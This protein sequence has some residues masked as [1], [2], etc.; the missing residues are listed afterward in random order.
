MI[1]RFTLA[2]LTIGAT[3]SMNAERISVEMAQKIASEFTPISTSKQIKGT[4]QTEMRLTY[5][6]ESKINPQESLYYVFNRNEGQGFVIVSP[7]DRLPAV[8]GYTDHGSF[9]IENIPDNMRW[10]L[11]QY[12]RQIDDY[13]N[14]GEDMLAPTQKADRAPIATLVSARWDQRSPFNNNTPSN[15]PAGCLAVAIGQ[16][17]HYHQYPA[18]GTGSHS[19]MHPTFGELSADFGN[20]SY[21]WDYMLDEYGYFDNYSDRQANAVAT[22]IYH[23]GVAVEMDYDYYGSGAITGKGYKALME[24]FGYDDSVE[25]LRREYFSADEWDEIMY[26]ELA[27]NRPVVYT[28]QA[29]EGGHAFVCDGYNT[30]GYYHI[31]WGW[32]GS[33]DGH[34]RLDALEPYG[35]GTGGYEG[36]YNEMQDVIIGIQKPDGITSDKPVRWGTDGHFVYDKNNT[37]RVIKDDGKHGGFYNLTPD[38]VKIY[39]GIKIVNTATE[40]VTYI[41]SGTGE[42]F[43]FFFGTNEYTVTRLSRFNDDGEYHIYPAYSTDGDNWNDTFVPHGMQEY[44]LMTIENGERTILN[45]MLENPEPKPSLKLNFSEL[46]EYFYTELPARIKG[47]I[48]NNGNADFSGKINIMLINDYTQ[49][50]MGSIDAEIAI[51]NTFTFETDVMLPNVESGNYKLAMMYLNEKA[52]WINIDYSKTITIS[53]TPAETTLYMLESEMSSTA[54]VGES[55]SGSLK[56]ANVSNNLFDGNLYMTFLPTSGEVDTPY[57]ILIA[58]SLNI[59]SKSI[60]DYQ[61]SIETHDLGEGK[62]IVGIASDNAATIGDSDIKIS[63]TNSIGQIESSAIKIERI[64]ERAI[65]INGIDSPCQID[66]YSIDGRMIYSALCSDMQQ[67]ILLPNEGIFIL[68]IGK[69]TKKIVI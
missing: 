52:E 40:E 55:L 45:S 32:G 63:I 60:I 25:Y 30:G 51:S 26:N 17:M 14:G 64:G 62:Y 31:N 11:S 49:H 8:L 10:W 54:S 37:F 18:Q 48:T 4:R 53:E 20:T 68:R 39:T 69:A 5:R 33:Y 23:C 15:C 41:Q 59:P 61:Y 57:T 21:D 16:I 9:D 12:E 22:L 66:V 27:N 13:L 42:S 44:L 7:D 67:E 50:T 38:V 56:I 65:R 58:E 34:F 1:K 47:K 29:P 35:Q 3:L 24:Y 6:A 36:G 19:Y 2:L 46:P 43:D 28:G